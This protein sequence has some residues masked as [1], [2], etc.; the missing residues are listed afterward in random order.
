MIEEGDWEANI[1]YYCLYE[2]HRFPS[3]FLSLSRKEKAFVVGA[4]QLRIAA[5]KKR[6]KEAERHSRR[7]RKG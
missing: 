1:A 6:R 3:E 4:I 7:R 2:F 5:E